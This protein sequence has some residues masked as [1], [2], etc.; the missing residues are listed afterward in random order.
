MKQ[1]FILVMHPKQYQLGMKACQ[2]ENHGADLQSEPHSKLDTSTDVINLTSLIQQVTTT[3]SFLT[4]SEVVRWS[5]TS[6]GCHSL[7]MLLVKSQLMWRAQLMWHF[8]LNK[9]LLP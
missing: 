4:S 8:N 1:M 3:H 7:F 6:W 5:S 2:W 9:Q